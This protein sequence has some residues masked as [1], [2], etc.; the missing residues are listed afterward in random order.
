MQDLIKRYFWVLGAVVAMICAIFAAKATGH[1][2]EAKFLSDPTK[3][4]VRKAVASPMTPA[5]QTHSKDGSSFAARNIFCSE[6]TPPPT[7]VNTDP[8]SIQ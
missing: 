7:V 1:I 2:V 5:K 3:A 6:C 8:S 4:P